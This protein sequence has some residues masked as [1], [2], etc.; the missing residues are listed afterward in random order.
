MARKYQITEQQIEELSVA[1]N[2]NKDK[3]VENRLKAIL[4]RGEGKKCTEIAKYTGYS[5]D[6][7]SKLISKYCNEGL[8]A[9]VEN[10]YKANHRNMTF[11]E[12]EA[13][14]EPFIEKAKL[15]QIV[16]VSEITKGY[17]QAIGRSISNSHGHIYQVLKRHGWRK[18]MPRSK[19]PN[20]ASEEVIETS[21]KLTM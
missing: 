20:K 14:L 2:N 11:E 10:N 3:N 5:A 17:E 12:E 8:D 9:I 15:G 18:I 4:M 21:K 7:V 1:R 6:H 13:L 16:E 19:H